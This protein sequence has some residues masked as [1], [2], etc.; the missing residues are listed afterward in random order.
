MILDKNLI[1]SELQAVTATAISANVIDLGINGIVP[2]EAAAA[3]MNLG[4]GNEIPFLLMVNEDFA[5]LT[6]L[7]VTI[8][9]SAAAA[10]TSPTV[11]YTSG[12]IPLATLKAGYKLPIRWMPD[13]PLLRYL[14]V[15]Y[16]VTGTTASAGKVTAVVATEV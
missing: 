13:A 2:Y 11:L 16:T 5:A 15:R 6:S 9:T 10:L 3:A 7:T 4:A 1:L 8:E 12:A 14:G